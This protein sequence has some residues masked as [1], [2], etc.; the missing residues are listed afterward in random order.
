MAGFAR[1]PSET[2]G[3]HGRIIRLPRAKASLAMP[4]SDGGLRRH[5]SETTVD[6]VRLI[7]L[8]RATASLAMPPSGWRASPGIR[9]K[10]PVDTVGLFGFYALRLLRGE[11]QERQVGRQ[12]D[13]RDRRQL[14][15]PAAEP[16][17][18]VVERPAEPA[19][20]DLAALDLLQRRDHRRPGNRDREGS[21][22]IDVVL[23]ADL[24]DAV[25]GADPQPLLAVWNAEDL[26]RRK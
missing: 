11:R 19:L 18:A 16:V 2:T 4:P 13:D 5:P 20:E 21:K 22:R 17:E 6:T 7:R 26:R 23:R 15:V 1:H 14:V 25:R 8:L 3:R 10:R 24:E 12:V 9:L